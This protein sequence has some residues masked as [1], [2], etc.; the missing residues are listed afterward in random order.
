MQVTEEIRGKGP[1][2]LRRFDQP[3]KDRIG[4]DLKDPRG[5]TNAQPPGQTRQHAH[6]QRHWR[7]LAMKDRAVMFWKIPVAADAVELPPRAATGMTIG[8]QV[9][10]PQPPAIVTRGVGAKGHRGVHGPGAVVRWGYGIG[11]SRRRW[12]CLASLWFTQGTMGLVRQARARFGC[13][14]T[15]ALGRDGRGWRLGCSSGWTRP[16]G[17]EHDA[18]PQQDEDHH[19]DSRRDVDSLHGPLT[20]VV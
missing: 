19:M 12:S 14:G 11:P 6:D 18:Q 4:I 16:E 8:P 1:Q 3:L 5:G 15:R 9:V 2:V 17:E 7:L 20:L 10:Q 13:G